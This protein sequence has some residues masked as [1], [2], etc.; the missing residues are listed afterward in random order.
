M[1]TDDHRYFILWSNDIPP[2]PIQMYMVL[3]GEG[4]QEA[5]DQ[6]MNMGFTEVTPEEYE[7]AE[8]GRYPAP[9]P[10]PQPPTIEEV[11]ERVTA[12]EVDTDITKR[13]LLEVT[14]MSLDM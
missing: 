9:D 1:Y 5:I 8:Q 14:M 12:L 3:I 13:G 6:L 10:Q 11:A 4:D 7:A 2:E